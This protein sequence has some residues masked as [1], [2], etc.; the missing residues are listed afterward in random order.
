MVQ[1]YVGKIQPSTASDKVITITSF[2]TEDGYFAPAGLIA[3]YHGSNVLNIGEVPDVYN[4]ND[5]AMEY[6]VYSG[7]WYHGVRAQGHTAKSGSPI[8]SVLS[9]IMEFVK[10]GTFPPLGLDQD[11]RWWSAIHDGIYNWVTDKGLTGPGK[12]CYLFV[13]PR[14]TDIKHT[15]ICQMCGIGSYAGQFPFDTPGMDAALISRDML[16]PAL[17]FAN[18]GKDV[19]T[20][21]M[22]N[23][24]DGWQW[25]T[26]D[27]VRSTAFSTR[28]VKQSFT[29]HGRFYEGHTILES[30]LA[31]MNEGVSLNYYSGHGTGGSGVS[32][33][34]RNI[35]Q[36]YPLCEPSSAKSYTKTWWD[37]WR[38]YMYDDAQTKDPRWGGFTW[39]NPSDTSGNLYDLVHYKW[40][41]QK[42]Q[43]IHSEMEIWMS[44]TTGQNFGPEIYLE[45]GGALW[46]G[47]AG[48]GL[49]PQEDLLD[50]MWLK[51]M[52]RNGTSLGQAFSTYVWLHQRDFTAKLDDPAKYDM[53]MYGSSTMQ[54]T[55][56]Q[57]I[58]GDP[59][60]TLCSPE[61][62]EPVPVL[63]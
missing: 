2:G 4:T 49:C 55:N 28:E 1:S 31:R 11:F 3:A 59:T 48:T 12:E 37:A 8:P 5:K 43:N 17:V 56:V 58:Y 57:V 6:R 32:F 20:S 18:P 45:H 15:I 34:Y 42:L 21:Q 26:N 16:Y 41:D 35:S 29:S 46:Y 40:I 47:N 33:M 9:M 25:T 27:G 53:S 22:M 63:P 23:F 61:W 13:A 19:T 30:W 38:G 10:N 36:E 24:P 60:L 7:S 39:F 51:D 52:T 44:C 54:V 14:W 50:D 62:T